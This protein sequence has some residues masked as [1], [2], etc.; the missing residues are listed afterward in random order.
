MPPVLPWDRLGKDLQRAILALAL[1]SASKATSGCMP[2]MVCDPPPPPSSAPEPGR[3]TFT[4]APPSLPTQAATAAATPAARAT[5]TAT[6]GTG[7][8]PAV[9]PMICDPLPPPSP[10]PTPTSSPT[11]TPKHVI[12]PMICDPLP[13]PT[14]TRA[15]K[16]ASSPAPT[17]RR[18]TL[19]T[20]MVCDPPPPP[21]MAATP[22]PMICDPP[23]PPA[24][25]PRQGAGSG[26]V[27]GAH[28]TSMGTAARL[29]LA[30]IRTVRIVQAG[31]LPGSEHPYPAGAGEPG[32]RPAFAAA[33]PWPD[34]TYIW[35]ASGGRLLAGG[36]SVIWQLPPAAR[37]GISCRWWRTGGP[38]DWP[39][40]RWC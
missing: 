3:P 5:P 24:G 2:P 23:P 36:D 25:D 14:P 4:R 34:A 18:R 31:D 20:P 16:P 6:R 17:A 22:T 26:L 38:R 19:V 32:D 15:A 1:L 12:T 37:A 35:S 10:A 39:W 30:E 8:Q 13:P 28:C 40:M 21:S 33:S 29:P 11:P 9:T 27:P 7:P